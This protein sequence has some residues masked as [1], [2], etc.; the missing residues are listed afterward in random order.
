MRS[1]PGAKSKKVLA[2]SSIPLIVPS[3]A[4]IGF[5]TC[6]GPVAPGSCSSSIVSTM[7]PFTTCKAEA[8]RAAA[9]DLDGDGAADALVRL[10]TTFGDDCSKPTWTVSRTFL[11]RPD[12]TLGARVDD[13]GGPEDSTVRDVD[14]FVAL[15]KGRIG[16]RGAVTHLPCCDQGCTRAGAWVGV[17]DSDELTV[18][19]DTSGA[20]PGG[21]SIS[22]G[23]LFAAFW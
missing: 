7:K 4:L 20:C 11:L 12:G 16:L 6:T 18:L 5:V 10:R 21:H 23:G 22:E 1:Q 15:P 14:T 8:W 3:P 17:V 19:G 2:L 13:H 9:P